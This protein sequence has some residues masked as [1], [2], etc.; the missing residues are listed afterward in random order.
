MTSELARMPAP[1]LKT[2][3][4]IRDPEIKVE[5][6]VCRDWRRDQELLPCGETCPSA[7]VGGGHLASSLSGSGLRSGFYASIIPPSSSFLG[8]VSP[9]MG[10]DEMRW[11]EM[12]HLGKSVFFAPQDILLCSTC[13]RPE[14]RRSE[15]L[16]LVS[17]R[18]LGTIG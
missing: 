5:K 7:R 4:H 2:T 13:K 17:F 12:G 10:R 14:R 15:V 18:Y 6:K 11:D 16:Y 9:N 8:S 1:G 3:D